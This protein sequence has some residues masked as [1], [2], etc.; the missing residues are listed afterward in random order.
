[1]LIVTS[2]YE[3]PTSRQDV[4]GELDIFGA[5]DVRRSLREAAD[6]GCRDLR[7]DLSGITFV[8]S[9]ALGHLARTWEN[10]TRSG[11]H[12]DIVATSASFD[13]ACQTSGRHF[14]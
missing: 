9:S 2:P 12:L 5:L 11:L 13:R 7:L 3:P 4:V 14:S 1:M 10:F 6:A 8:D